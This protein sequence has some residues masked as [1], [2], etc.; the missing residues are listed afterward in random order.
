MHGRRRRSNSRAVSD[1]VATI[2]LLALTVTLFSSIFFFVNTFPRP[3]PSPA[4]QF[5]AKL[6]YGSGGTT[7]TGVSVLHLSGPTVAGNALVYLYSARHPNAFPTPFSVSQGIGGGS[8]WNLGQSWVLN[9]T[10]YGLAAPD[11]ITI[12][13]VTNSLLLFR[14]TLPGTNP[15]IPPTFV[16]VGVLPATP[17][18]GQPFTVYADILDDDLNTHSVFVNLS[19]IPGITG[20][21]RFS[22]TYS[23]ANGTWSY[24]VRAGTTTGAG[25]FFAFINATDQALQPN[26]IAFTIPIAAVASP[27]SVSLSANPAA[28]INN[29]AVSLITYVQNL[30]AGSATVTVQYVVSGTPI[31]NTSG[32]VGGGSTAAFT[33]SWTPTAPGVYLISV[34]ANTSGTGATGASLNLTVFPSILLLS[35]NVP[36]GTRTAFNG[37][38]FLAQELTAAGFPFSTMFVSCTSAIPTS[39]RSYNVV[40]IDFG[41][42]WGYSSCPKAP[43][44]TDQ[45]TITGSTSTKFLVTGSNAFGL[46]S[47]SSYSSSF[48]AEFGI[49]WQ[50]GSTCVTVPNSTASATW[51]A[52]TGVGLRSDGIPS[53]MTINA[54]L[55]GSNHHIPYT[56]FALGTTNTAFLKGGTHPVGAYAAKGS[57]VTGIALATSTPLLTTPLPSGNSWGTGTAGTAV[58]YNALNALCGL[59]TSTQTG[60]ALTDFAVAQSTLVGQSHSLVSTVY[61]GLRANGPV[62]APVTALLYVNGTPATYNGAS[63]S[64]TAEVGAGGQVAFVTL[65]WQAPGG[66]AYSLSVVIVVS[67]SDYFS[68][69]NQIAMSILNQPTTFT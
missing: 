50:S 25:R 34:F 56:Y 4:N 15:N 37:S 68:P 17:G 39:I 49:T 60:R 21:G 63:V 27:L 33:R 48:F 31:G 62:G 55:A 35:H 36:S 12:S 23:A 43:S 46:T 42:N 30:A 59:S 24:Y 57:F 64:A 58:I 32:V 29:S 5:S 14:V 11:N 16:N 9:V 3:Q 7:I 8:V 54:T 19:Q 51:S 40:I 6:A 53:S 18:V 41:S 67:G 28:P 1:V 13:I 45:G 2:L 69:N 22:M 44:T 61:V 10:S 66:G 65:Y 20:T 26:S 47:C 52:A 38:S